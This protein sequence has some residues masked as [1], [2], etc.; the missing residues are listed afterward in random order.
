MFD[1]GDESPLSLELWILCE[2][3]VEDVALF[4]EI[5]EFQSIRIP[6]HL[7]SGLWPICIGGSSWRTSSLQIWG[8][9]SFE[10]IQFLPESEVLL[11]SLLSHR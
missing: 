10:G 8:I 7:G 1:R 4:V 11:D 6:L 9:V 3:E 5:D 2:G